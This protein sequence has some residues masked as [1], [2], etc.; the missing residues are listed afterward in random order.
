MWLMLLTLRLAPQ[1]AFSVGFG[2]L[3][4]CGHVIWE[5][6]VT[7]YGWSVTEDG[8]HLT[9]IALLGALDGGVH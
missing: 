5:S 7:A 2:S 9:K 6:T 1:G 3:G 8:E 4:R